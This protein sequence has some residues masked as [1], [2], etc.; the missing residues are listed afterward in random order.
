MTA[1]N[2]SECGALYDDLTSIR[3]FRQKGH[4]GDHCGVDIVTWA[5]EENGDA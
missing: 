3:C 2:D 1:M 5:Q 4:P